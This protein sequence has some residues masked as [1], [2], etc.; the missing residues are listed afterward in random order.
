MTTPWRIY[1]TF[2]SGNP[3]AGQNASF[4]FPEIE[5]VYYQIVF[6]AW[7]FVTSAAVA[8]RTPRLNINTREGVRRATLAPFI[9]Q[10]AGQD[11]LWTAGGTSVTFG[12]AAQGF[13]NLPF[14]DVLV[15][16]GDLAEIVVANIQAA[17][18]LSEITLSYVAHFPRKVLAE[19]LVR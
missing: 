17:D 4:R 13:V 3:G 1:R 11:V 15:E 16:P 8:T 18:Q 9:D 19:A 7:R 12:S 14:Q 10:I 5:A 6:T 2:V